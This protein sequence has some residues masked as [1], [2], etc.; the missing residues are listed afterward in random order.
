MKNLEIG[1]MGWKKR[2]RRIAARQ[3]GKT[4]PLSQCPARVRQTLKGECGTVRVFAKQDTKGQ[5]FL[6][7]VP[8][9]SD[10]FPTVISGI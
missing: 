8:D 9:N 10:G 1:S 5:F 6:S 3:Q 7:Y 2:I 4:L